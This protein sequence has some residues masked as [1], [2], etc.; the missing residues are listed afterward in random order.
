MAD[1]DGRTRR[2]R[3]IRGEDEE[4]EAGGGLALA[5]QRVAPSR[6]DPV[7]HAASG[8]V[9]GPAGR[10]VAP[11]RTWWKPLYVVLVLTVVA[12]ALAF[13]EKYPCSSG[14]WNTANFHYTHVCYT[15]IY[16]LYFGEH[17]SDGYTPYFDH[18]VE[19]PVVI[20]GVMQATAFIVA[21]LSTDPS[22]RGLLFYV[23]NVLL[24]AG[25]AL[26]TTWALVRLVGRRRPWDA[27][28]FA[29]APGLVLAAYINWDLVA[30]FLTTTAMLAWARRR[31]GWAGVL[32]G[33]AVA[34]KFYPLV[35]LGPLLVLCLRT[36]RLRELGATVLTMAGTWLAVN[37]PI[38]ATAYDGWVRFYSFSR[39][40][41]ADWGSTWYFVEHVVPGV[42]G[43]PAAE[44]QPPPLLNPVGAGSFAL[45][46]VGVA[47]LALLA[48]RRPRWPQLAF[49]TL[50]AFL[51]T[52]K[53]W[54]PQYVLWLLPLAVL[55]RPRWRMFL[56]WQLSEIVYFL[57]IWWYLYELV[58]P[59]KGLPEGLYLVA[60]LFRL[61]AV[62]V[63]CGLVVR[64][65]LRPE[66]DPVRWWGDDDP[67]GGPLDDA[68][69]RF[70]LRPLVPARS[71]PS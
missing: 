4:G 63:L 39:T 55:A 12:C 48:P 31:P 33:L 65:V 1:R 18:P 7:V 40:R 15:D 14:G 16:P 35:L 51:V 53:V 27:A 64:D 19:Y 9:G 5:A 68:P 52:N 57:A 13:A 29:V 58:K 30:V 11:G 69:D 8:I 23:V 59:G 22:V 61:V 3:H 50:A 20:G 60:L 44:G 62:A 2:G 10:R 24:L 41:P 45:L 56:V 47:L 6:E 49:L 26:G 17:L 42:F 67:A 36:G 21:P 37:V 32:L 38:M 46:C 70:T 54:S 43:S 71:A 66:R 28:M 34:T 25:C